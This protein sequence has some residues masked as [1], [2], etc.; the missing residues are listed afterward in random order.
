MWLAPD[1]G[2][3]SDPVRNKL[4]QTIFPGKVDNPNGGVI[5]QL[6]KYIVVFRILNMLN[7]KL[8]SYRTG[9][10]RIEDQVSEGAGF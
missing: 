9:A 2:F 4:L 3:N 10:L 8:K 5:N 6:P 7:E 1:L